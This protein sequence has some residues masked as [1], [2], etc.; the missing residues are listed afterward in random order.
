MLN[1]YLNSIG[2]L[3]ENGEFV[4]LKRVHV[5]PLLSL[6]HDYVTDLSNYR[7]IHQVRL[8]VDLANGH[9]LSPYL[10]SLV[11]LELLR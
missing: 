6:H 5:S 8:T 2:E 1:D 3:F 4:T 10:S 11:P 7:V 9:Y